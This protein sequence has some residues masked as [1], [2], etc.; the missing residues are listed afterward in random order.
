MYIR[1]E[2][3]WP[4]KLNEWYLKTKWKVAMYEGRIRVFDLVDWVVYYGDWGEYGENMGR[5]LRDSYQLVFPY[6]GINDCV[7]NIWQIGPCIIIYVWW[8]LAR[9]NYCV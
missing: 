5:L 2:G 4:V 6:I 9:H 8:V 7:Q 3:I 1:K